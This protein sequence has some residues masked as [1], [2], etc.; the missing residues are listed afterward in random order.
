VLGHGPGAGGLVAK[1][2]EPEAAAFL[3]LLNPEE[4]GSVIYKVYFRV[5]QIFLGPDIPP[6]WGK[7]YK[8]T[9]EL[10]QMAVNYSKWS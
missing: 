6:N 3:L 8:M 5:A 10:Y 7:I 2:K 4:N 1:G 9:Y